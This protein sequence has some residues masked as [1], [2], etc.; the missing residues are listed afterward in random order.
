MTSSFFRPMLPSPTIVA[1]VKYPMYAS[2]PP[3]GVRCIAMEGKLLRHNLKEFPPSFSE[4][5]RRRPELDGFDGVMVNTSTTDHAV[6]LHFHVWDVAYALELPY[7]SRFTILANRWAKLPFDLHRMVSI[8]PQTLV[9]D[10]EGLMAFMQTALNA[11]SVQII[12]RDPE[13]PYKYGRAT[14]REGFFMTINL[15]PAEATAHEDDHV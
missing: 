14:E 6:D 11:G 8:V 9:R 4:P 7:T 15:L 1:N 13:G 10:E 3:D 5:F 12:L 2:L